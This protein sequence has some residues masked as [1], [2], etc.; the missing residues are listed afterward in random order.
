MPRRGAYGGGRVAL[1]GMVKRAPRRKTMAARRGRA[2]KAMKLQK[3]ELKGIDV[4]VGVNPAPTRTIGSGNNAIVPVNVLTQGTGSYERIGRKVY[5]E[6]IRLKGMARYRS[7]TNS[8]ALSQ[9]NDMLIR[10]VLDRQPQGIVPSWDEIFKGIPPSGTPVSYYYSDLNPAQTGRFRVLKE[11]RLQGFAE[12]IADDNNMCFP[13]DEYLKLNHLEA[14]YDCTNATPTIAQNKTNAIY[15]A[16][17]AF[18]DDQTAGVAN[19][20]DC[21]DMTARLRYRDP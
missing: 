6:S 19:F 15:I 4:E 20:W 12:T 9:S 14:I 11:I 5:L 16:Y 17:S 21:T 18:Q 10:V 1:V 2:K 3:P 7:Q 8:A 13:I